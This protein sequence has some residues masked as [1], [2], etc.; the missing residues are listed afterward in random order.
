MGERAAKM[1]LHPGDIRVVYRQQAMAYFPHLFRPAIPFLKV[2]N[3]PR[4]GKRL[5]VLDLDYSK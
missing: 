3:P 1:L 5:L 4:P 2:M